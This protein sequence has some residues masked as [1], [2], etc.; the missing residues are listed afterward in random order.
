MLM[1][2]TRVP[3]TQ[4]KRGECCTYAVRKRVPS[5]YE[6]DITEG[7]LGLQKKDFS[8][9]GGPDEKGRRT[10][11]G[12]GP[13]T[14]GGVQRDGRVQ[15]G[16]GEIDVLGVVGITRGQR[17]GT[18]AAHEYSYAEHGPPKAVRQAV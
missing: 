16:G 17:Q 3:P 4:A 14:C 5:L 13:T 7:L 6:S 12:E 11:A 2:P 18:E 9:A 8:A 10:G 15:L 1:W